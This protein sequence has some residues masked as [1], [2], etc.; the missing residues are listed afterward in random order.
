MFI[1]VLTC[2]SLII[3]FN[4]YLVWK[5]I[6]IRKQLREVA[7]RLEALEKKLPLLIKLILLNLRKK[8]ARALTIRKK[9]ESLQQK[10]QALLTII[11]LVRRFS[12][13]AIALPKKQRK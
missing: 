1:F 3:I 5:A 12:P 4:C 7:N 6:Q 11:Q 13:A 2:Q 9:Y 10:R 8:E